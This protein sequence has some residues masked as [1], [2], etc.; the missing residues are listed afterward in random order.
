MRNATQE[1]ILLL[2]HWLQEE[3]NPQHPISTVEI[4]LRWEE[5]DLPTDRRSVYNDIQTLKK[6]GYKIHS[7]RSASNAYWMESDRFQKSKYFTIPEIGML[8]DAIQSCRC[9]SQDDTEVLIHK[10]L[11]MVSKEERDALQRPVY[12]DYA[13]KENGKELGVKLTVLFQAIAL[14]KKVLFHQQY[15]IF[16]PEIH[17]SSVR[18]ATILSPYYIHYDREHYHVVGWS[19]EHGEIR[20]YRIDR[21]TGIQITKQKSRKRPSGFDPDISGNSLDAYSEH[22][23][24]ITLRCNHDSLMEIIDRYGDQIPIRHIKANQY[25]A[26]IQTELSPQFSRWIALTNLSIVRI[27]DIQSN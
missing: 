5:Q 7:A 23:G 19:E 16:H 14:K 8:L 26:V 11:W 17:K 21:I 2:L 12:T 4:L 1:R 20:S 10:L 15:Y 6:M 27:C 22:P 9:I 13:Y 24:E 25:E 3:T 18:K